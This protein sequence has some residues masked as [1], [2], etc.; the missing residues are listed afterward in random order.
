MEF[1]QRRD[2]KF[3]VYNKGEWVGIAAQLSTGQYAFIGRL[4]DRLY[5]AMTLDGLA[6][7]IQQDEEEEDEN[8]V[9]IESG[10]R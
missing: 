4:D 8:G 9:F 7:M 1:S 10:S 3:E 6:A 2:G 5:I